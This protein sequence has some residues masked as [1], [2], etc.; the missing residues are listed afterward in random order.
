MGNRSAIT[1]QDLLLKAQQERQRR[2]RDRQNEA[3]C[4]V[5]Q[6]FIRKYLSVKYAIKEFSTSLD[7]KLVYRMVLVFGGRL[8]DHLGVSEL[9]GILAE[10][11]ETLRVYSE[12]LGN[13]KVCSL[14][15][16]YSDDSL[17]GNTVD[18]LNE[19]FPVLQEFVYSLLTFLRN[20]EALNQGA[21]GI[22][23]A[24]LK[25]WKLN[26]SAYLDP[27]FKISIKEVRR[28]S[29]LQR[30]YQAAGSHG[31][32]PATSS[33]SSTMLENLAYIYCHIKE[34]QEVEICLAQ[35][36]AG[37][38][39]TP[40]T[41]EMQQYVSQLYEKQFID[42][43]ANLLELGNNSDIS[44]ENLI[45]FIN[46]APNDSLRDSVMIT[47]LSRPMFLKKL[48]VDV[49]QT[50]NGIAD[51]QPSAA[52]SIFIKLLEMHLLVSTDHEL[53]SES[54][55][56]TVED[57]VAFTTGLKDF[58]FYNLWNQPAES[59]PSILDDTLPLLRK[60]YLRDSRLHFCR[61]KKDTDYWSSSNPDFLQ[62][63]PFRYIEDYER[64]YRDYA[65]KRDEAYNEQESQEVTDNMS[66]IKFRI[67]EQLMLNYKSSVSTRQFKKLEILIKAP[68]FI[69]FKQ[70]VDLFYMFIAL[71]KQRLHLDDDSA[72]LNML[73][74][75][76]ANNGMG[77]QMATISR[78]NILEDACNAF[79]S[80]GERFKAKL[81]VT[82]VNEFGPEAGID[83]GGITKEFL[84]SV[85]EEGFNNKRYDLFETNEQH[86][87]YPTTEVTPRKLRYLWFLGKVLGKCLYDHVLIDVT[88]ADFF[89][90]K[91]LSPAT[92]FVSSFDDLHSLDHVL[93]SNLVKLLSM[94]PE[95]L[96]SLDLSFEVN[97]PNRPG[98]IVELIPDGSKKKVRK[99][100]VLLYI[101]KVADYKLNKSLFRQTQNFHGG[102]SMI[103][104]PHWMEMFNS[105][106]LQMLISGGGKDIDLRDLKQNTEYGGFL[107]TD[108]TITDFWAILKEFRPEERLNFIKFVTSVPRAPLQG[109]QSLE[110]KFGIR[111]AGRELDRLPT[112]ST[113]VNLLKLPDYQ[114]KEL[115]REKLLYSINSGA[116][117]D[118]S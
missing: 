21:I 117:F 86:E 33:G 7:H 60:V 6:C 95:Q 38:I 101:I 40:Q 76:G 67:L 83:G 13:L 62:V 19:S 10:S 116:R 97:D 91:M 15:A 66:A 8:A 28:P 88:F 9:A 87:L 31:I 102:M 84:T 98:S 17:I 26:R 68:F 24:V 54:F 96:E 48:Y 55:G 75:W 100:N 85:S 64:L 12:P 47:L 16:R 50:A 46:C 14:I 5:I 11:E 72:M 32:L 53:L 57:L 4:K 61:Q 1:K 103:I 115:L 22:I 41:P 118:L 25:R 52:F 29:L 56:F 69:P 23:F 73:M 43:L 65:D 49:S 36:F 79:N 35:C 74:P 106:E 105:V 18:C 113:C 77:R 63:S 82:F 30:F 78:E 81:A 93:H 2:A 20:T 42:R 3:A 45:S 58:V 104:A 70:R 107:E 108:K 44:I 94:S 37:I 34:K 51:F 90:K 109:F 99:E 39:Y 71:D 114:N 27:L 110:P 112:A 92:Q 80:I 59:R 89:L 111:N